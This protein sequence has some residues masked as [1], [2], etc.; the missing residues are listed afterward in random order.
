MRT[1]SIRAAPVDRTVSRRGFI[2]WLL[3]LSVAGLA[4]N[5]LY[6]VGRFLFPAEGVKSSGE[7]TVTVGF[8]KDIPPGRSVKFRYRGYPAILINLEGQYYAYGAICTHLGCIVHWGDVKG[9]AMPM[10]DEVHCVCHAGHF[11]SRTGNVLAGPPPSPL[12]RLNVVTRGEE[13][14][15]VGWDN[16][17]YVKGLSTYR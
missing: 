8:K 16:P 3:G 11:D 13:V 2:N 5:A 15:A 10:G 4:V 17:G 1:D 12:P 9:C 14:V 7:Q 6:T